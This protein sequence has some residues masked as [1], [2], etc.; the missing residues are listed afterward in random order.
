MNSKGFFILNSQGETVGSLATE[1]GLSVVNANKVYADNIR[2]VYEGDSNLYVNHDYTGDSDGSSS[3]P[4]KSFSDLRAYL[5]TTPVIDKD[6]V[7]NI[8]TKSEIGES[9]VLHN[10]EGNGSLKFQYSKNAIHRTNN[11]QQWCIN[12][13]HISVGLEI[14]GGRTSY[15]TSDGA[16][17][18]DSGNQHGIKL[19]NCHN[20]L[21]TSLAIN[22]VNWG[23]YLYDSQGATSYIDFCKTHCAFDLSFKSHVYDYDS[24]GNCGQYFRLYTGSTFIY[25]SSGGGYKPHGSKVEYSGKYFLVGGER[26]DTNSF[27]TPPPKPSTSDQYGTWS[28]TDYG[29][30]SYGRNG[31][32]VNK[33][34]PGSKKIQQGEWSGLGNNYGFAFFNDS[35]IRSWLS[36]GT[37]KDGSTI[38]VKRASEGGYSSSQPIYLHGATNTSCSGTPA[39]LKSYGTLGSLAWGETKTFNL[40]TAAVNDLKSGAIKSLCFY[41]SSGSSY[42]KLTAVSIKLKANR[43]V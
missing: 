29:Y 36:N 42:V 35:A 3:K 12:M 24:C 7:V 33:W 15:N 19:Y 43:P 41:D 14:N 38:T 17:L 1:T 30:F 34:N 39:G 22:C 40:P 9:L 26:T 16:L 37:P 18:C 23:I 28:M 10:I 32:N 31:I 27:R 25:G 20:F 5:S 8:V 13:S 4:F 2:N 6:V 11:D 21:I